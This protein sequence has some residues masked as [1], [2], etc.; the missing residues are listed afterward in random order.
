MKKKGVLFV[1]FVLPLFAYMFFA[2]GVNHF[3]TLPTISS[4]VAELPR[5]W[6][7]SDGK[8]AVLSGHISILCFGGADIWA[9]RG[10]FFTLHQKIY[11]SYREF[12]DYQVVIIVPPEAES[13]AI[14]LLKA[15]DPLSRTDRYRLLVA[16]KSEIQ[17]YFESFHL[18]TRLNAQTGSPMVFIV[19][20]KRDLRGRKGKSE[21]GT[22]EY[23]EGY[24][25]RSAAELH[26]EMTDDVKIILAE[27]RLALK[28]NNAYRIK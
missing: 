25:T 20:K 8:P 10:N 15:L 23:K 7:T 17:T 19:D 2:T 16:P 21:K 14:R 27:Y 4:K 9:H 3:I 22:P 28:R 5:V 6:R 13:D 24:D 18:Q 11:K 12:T 1:L 26:Q